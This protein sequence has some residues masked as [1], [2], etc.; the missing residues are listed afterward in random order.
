MEYLGGG[1]DLD[2]LVRK[3]G[4]QPSARVAQILGQVCGALHEA[5]QA[6]LIHRDIKPANIIL[7]ERGGMPDVAKVI[8][9]GLVK[10]LTVDDGRTGQVVLGSDYPWDMGEA[11][12]AAGI[13]SVDG[14][15]RDD[16]DR[17]VGSTAAELLGLTE[18]TTEEARR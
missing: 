1:I 4:P 16:L 8:D 14:V 12:P 5:H 15:A 2:A 18:G 10:P 17:I 11:D 3:H 6:Q 7:C 9:F 13:G